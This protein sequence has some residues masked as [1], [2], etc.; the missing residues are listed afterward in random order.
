MKSWLEKAGFPLVNVR[1]ENGELRIS[2]QKFSYLPNDDAYVWQVPIFLERD[3]KKRKILQSVFNSSSCLG[4]I[5]RFEECIHTF[6]VPYTG[7]RNELLDVLKNGKILAGDAKVV[8]DSDSLFRHKELS[9][10]P[11]ERTEHQNDNS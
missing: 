8:V 1:E 6:P 2:Q 3:G 5:C 9:E 10:N 4:Y 7:S 11:A